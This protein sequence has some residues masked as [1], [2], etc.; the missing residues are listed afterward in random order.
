MSIT[1]LS[2]SAIL[3]TCHFALGSHVKGCIIILSKT[4][5][6]L[7]NDYCEYTA[8]RKEGSTEGT[9][10]VILPRGE[11]KLLVYDDEDVEAKNSA[12]NSTITISGTSMML[13]AG[14]YLLLCNLTNPY[15][16]SSKHKNVTV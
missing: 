7:G 6:E 15:T 12:Y 16:G 1:Y 3:I 11:Y 14:G 4:I 13:N 10:N 2:G 9:V 5:D 8:I